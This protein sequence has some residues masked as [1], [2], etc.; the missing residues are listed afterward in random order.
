MH[1]LL[2]NYINVVMYRF[3]EILVSGNNICLESYFI[4]AFNS[5]KTLN[6]I[7]KLDYFI[8][9]T[10]KGKINIVVKLMKFK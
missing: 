4:R 6:Y 9:N 7:I 2:H 1:F 5:L 10:C 3:I 8:I